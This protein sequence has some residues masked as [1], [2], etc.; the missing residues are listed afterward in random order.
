[1]HKGMFF[2]NRYDFRDGA[3]K[4]RSG[5]ASLS[6]TIER[7]TAVILHLRTHSIVQE[8]LQICLPSATVSKYTY[9]PR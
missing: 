1:M 8:S 3:K 7:L 4:F 9:L 6:V 2:K 5:V